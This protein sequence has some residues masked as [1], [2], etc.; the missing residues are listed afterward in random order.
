M[1]LQAINNQ[2]LMLFKLRCTAFILQ[3]WMYDAINNQLLIFYM[4]RYSSF[5]NGIV[6]I[7]KLRLFPNTD[8]I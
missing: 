2:L 8:I 4:L 3:E 6:V 5:R 1:D 7:D